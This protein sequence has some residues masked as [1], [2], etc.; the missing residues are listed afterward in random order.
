MPE[1]VI[2]TGGVCSGKTTLRK[3]NFGDSHI[4]IDASDIF[5]HLSAGAYLDFPSIHRKAMNAIGKTLALQAFQ[6]KSDIVIEIVGDNGDK[7]DDL[8]ND[9]VS[10]GYR[11]KVIYVNCDI[12][13]AIRRNDNRDNDDVSAYYTEEYHLKWIKYA[14]NALNKKRKSAK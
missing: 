4:S 7:F 12:E 5:L 14:V 13:E 2:F 8:I 3:E 1:V 10:I 6:N 9:I 11:T